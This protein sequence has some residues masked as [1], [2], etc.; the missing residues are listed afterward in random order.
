MT[1][2]I[3]RPLWGEVPMDSD[4]ISS[5]AVDVLVVGAGIAGVTTALEV[6]REGRN[7][8][9]VEAREAGT[10]TTGR[11]TAKVTA[12]HAC[13]YSKIANRNGMDIAHKYAEGQREALQYFADRHAER[14]N[15]C[16]FT[17]DEISPLTVEHEVTRAVG[18]DTF[19]T[20][21]PV[22]PGAKAALIYPNQFQINPKNWLRELIHEFRQLGGK[23]VTN[24]RIHTIYDGEPVVAETDNGQ[25]TATDIVVATHFPISNRIV[26]APRLSTYMAHVVAGPSTLDIP[27]TWISYDDEVSVRTA[28]DSEG[29]VLVAVGE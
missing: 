15:H 4:S 24:A 25:I 6:Q 1:T 21:D 14:V 5:T 13:I 11:T 28:Y 19:L 26:G 17:D 22:L 7:V 10:G 29:P 23:Y 9:L 20:H 12:G 18:F 27:D 16:V 3:W 8:L 2:P